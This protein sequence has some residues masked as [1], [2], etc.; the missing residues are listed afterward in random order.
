MKI[1]LL[2]RMLSFGG[3]ERQLVA[4]AKGL[5]SRGADVHV[6]LFY[7]GGAFD[8]ELVAA[9]IPVHY[10]GKKSRWDVLGFLAR[11]CRTVSQLEPAVVYS[12][13]DLPNILAA[14]FRR[15]IGRPRLIWSIRAAGVEMQHY[16][17][18]TRFIPWVEARLSSRAFRVIANSQAGAGW[19]L[20]RGFAAD[21]IS[22]VENGIDTV[23]FRPDPAARDRVR[24]DWKVGDDETL[25]G[26]PGRLDTMK[27]H[28]NF[29]RACASLAAS[30]PG[31]CFVCIGSGPAG[32]RDELAALAED[33][34]IGARLIWA[35]PR[36]DMPAVYAALDLACSASAFG[37]GFSNVVGEA[38]AC[39]VPCVVTD[40]GDSARIVGDCGEVVVPR[41]PSQLALAMEEMLDRLDR[42]PDLRQRA[43][44]RIED[45]FS[46][47]S[48]VE[49]TE[50][51]LW[52][53][54]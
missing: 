47:P 29:L 17:W 24:R 35:G 16:D 13:L 1:I 30:R 42:E 19:A 3:A 2:A 11:F 20:R 21:R 18:L 26:L 6:V 52:G 28:P 43:R 45:H 8:D 15:L 25:V 27:D 5:N 7:K 54:A 53:L 12:F 49:R 44:A 36:Q 10:L 23:R 50:R 46:V 38:M 48:M 33:L 31:L 37:E 39:G 34:G 14:L 51:I 41:D 40:V 22:V 4:L 32:Y 9:G